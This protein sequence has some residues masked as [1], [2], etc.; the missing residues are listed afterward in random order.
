MSRAKIL[1]VSFLHCGRS[2][3]ADSDLGWNNAR[4]LSTNTN[5]R[6]GA[7]NNVG[8]FHYPVLS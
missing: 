4:A 5:A 6:S 8:E 2:P 1:I 7:Q 3:G